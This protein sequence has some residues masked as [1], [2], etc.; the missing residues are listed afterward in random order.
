ML[1]TDQ[2]FYIMGYCLLACMYSSIQLFLNI[3]YDF[4]KI[5]MCNNDYDNF[6]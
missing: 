5:Q 6:K 2:G 4:L 3:N 1:A